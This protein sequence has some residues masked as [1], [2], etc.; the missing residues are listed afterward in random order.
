MDTLNLLAN[1]SA[2][3][4][5]VADSWSLSDMLAQIPKFFETLSG[6]GKVG[7]II[8]GVLSA[9]MVVIFVLY[10][11]EIKAAIYRHTQKKREES[12]AENRT[13]NASDEKDMSQGEDDIEKLLK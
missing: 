12:K 1:A 10:K 6:L 11:N 9:A 7:L 4:A 5:G 8:A 2:T 13:D 3:E